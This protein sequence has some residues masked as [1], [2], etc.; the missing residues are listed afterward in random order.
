MI[1]QKNTKIA[2]VAS[3]IGFFLLILLIDYSGFL[4]QYNEYPSAVSMHDLKLTAGSGSPVYILLVALI[5]IA[6]SVFWA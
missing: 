2:I 3:L 6:L 1:M 5:F 4:I